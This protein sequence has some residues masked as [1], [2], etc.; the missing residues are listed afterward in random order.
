MEVLKS[1]I[2]NRFVRF[3]LRR[4]T[5]KCRIDGKSSLNIAL[6]LFSGAR[7]KACF[8]CSHITLP[9]VRWAISKG[10]AAFGV[11]EEDLK[12][13]FKDPYWRTGLVD[14]I[15]GIAKYGVKKPFVPGAPFL[16]VWD[17]TYA[18]NLRCK[19]CYASAGK[20]LPNEFSTREALNTADE[21]ADA[22]VTAVAFSGGEPLMRKDLFDT[23][24]RLRDNGVFTAVATNGTLI[25]REVAKK[26][27]DL[28]AGF[29]QISLDGASAETHD[30]FRGV[31]GAYERTLQAIKNCVENGLFVEISTTATRMNYDEVPKIAD[32]CEGIGVD[33]Y[34][35][36]NFV[37]TGRGY[38]MIENDLTPEDREKLL[39]ILWN[40]LKSGGK[41]QYLST[42]PQFARVALQE[43]KDSE[44]R[45]I[46]GHFYNPTLMG[47][48]TNLGDFIG[49]CGAGRMYAALEP[50]GTL[51]PCV[52]LPLKL[53]NL[54]EERFEDIWDTHPILQTLRDRE[55][56]KGR[57]KTCKYRDVCGGC[58]ARAY[59]YFGDVTAPDPGCIYNK[60]VFY[61][62]KTEFEE[63]RVVEV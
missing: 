23:M 29:V 20:P 42:A 21:L 4:L 39:K 53:G 59:G 58:R 12:T 15:K 8:T 33:W 45:I 16:I 30:S 38:F 22:G 50:E 27:A 60:D 17:Y 13:R 57:C 5:H 10:G 55:K 26:L 56:L 62:L 18:C 7:E 48:L 37:P 1:T 40:R 2:D 3:L 28:G 51:Q 11:S 54:R 6:E 49:G 25:T 61:K 35:I 46:P 52:F 14:V 9:I 63:E 24:K 32:L 34:M 19:H 41:L 44:K 31:P 36:F 47:Q 43:E